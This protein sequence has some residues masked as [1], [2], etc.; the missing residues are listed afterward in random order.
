M[1]YF[2]TLCGKKLTSLNLLDQRLKNNSGLWDLVTIM[3]TCLW[4]NLTVYGLVFILAL[5]DWD[6][7]WLH[8]L[9][10]REEE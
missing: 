1:N 9:S 2:R 6:I 10:N 4:M 3:W 5:V 7:Q 8:T